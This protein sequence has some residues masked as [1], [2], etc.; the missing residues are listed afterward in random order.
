M[1]PSPCLCSRSL[2]WLNTGILQVSSCRANLSLQQRKLFG[3]H[4]SSAACWAAA[5]KV[6]GL[7]KIVWGRVK[8]DCLNVQ[9]DCCVVVVM[10]V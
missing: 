7:A 3:W 1:P 6:G 8:R 2:L 5:C 9:K 4:V 10:M